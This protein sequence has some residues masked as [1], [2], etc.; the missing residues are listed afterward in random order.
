MIAAAAFNVGGLGGLVGF[1]SL[2]MAFFLGGGLGFE[3]LL[4]LGQLFGADGLQFQGFDGV[5]HGADFI[6]AACVRNFSRGIP[7]HD[8]LRDLREGANG[9]G[10]DEG[11]DDA[12]CGY[13]K[14]AGNGVQ[15]CIVIGL[16]ENE[17]HRPFGND[18]PGNEH[19]KL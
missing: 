4:F 16:P 13:D 9:T 5:G 2:A 15:E 1:L 6:A 12:D 17:H 14:R 19:G 18:E 3:A 11:G 7:I 10:E 8:L